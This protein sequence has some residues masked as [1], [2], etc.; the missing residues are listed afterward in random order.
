MRTQAAKIQIMLAMLLIGSLPA[1]GGETG[2]EE[3]AHVTPTI[4]QLLNHLGFDPTREDHVRNG[5]VI[6]IGRPDDESTETE[7]AAAA[8]MLVV[9]RPL[10]EV[11]AAYMN[12]DVFRI[13][14]SI[15]HWHEV[16]AAVVTGEG[17]QEQ[18]ESFGYE[19]SELREAKKFLA[20][21]PGKQVNLSSDEFELLGNLSLTGNAVADA[22]DG[23]RTLLAERFSRYLRS[24]LAGIAA[25]DRGKGVHVDPAADI[26]IGVESF[27]FLR[28]HYPEFHGLL[29]SYPMGAGAEPVAHQFYWLKQLV[30]ERP[31]VVLSHH[32][33]KVDAKY[34]VAV[35]QQFYIGHSLNSL[36]A[37][38][39]CL[40]YEGGTVVFYTN[41]IFTDQITGFASNMK[42]RV[43]RERLQEA[44][45]NLLEALRDELEGPV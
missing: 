37:V 12:G 28:E 18:F 20:A 2:G 17:W 21:K 22:S 32:T 15:L 23:Y 36:V 33:F 26:R 38:I 41:R 19:D 8:V 35:D 6:T 43:G 7:L 1:M 14:E 39:G 25:Y 34:A 4:S 40:P 11:V 31:Q 9:R 3:G 5:Q 16:D 10:E 29:E 44:V 13:D 45:A 24:G 27:S 42:R 30:D